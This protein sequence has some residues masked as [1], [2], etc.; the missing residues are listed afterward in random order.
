MDW[1]EG[2]VVCSYSEIVSLQNNGK[3]QIEVYPNPSQDK[4]T[5]SGSLSP[6]SR[7]KIVTLDGKVMS[8]GSLP[9]DSNTIDI[10]NFG[11]GV[12]LICI[13]DNKNKTIKKIVKL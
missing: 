3:R 5:I 9:Y 4:T 6:Q 1:S 7:Y 13:E 8:E 12:Y 11:R 2:Y 10:S